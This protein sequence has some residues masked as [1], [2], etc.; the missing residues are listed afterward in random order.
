[1]IQMWPQRPKLLHLGLFFSA[2]LLGCGLAEL[3]GT[4]PGTK[5]TIWAPGGIF[6]ATLIASPRRTWP[7]WTLAGCLAE[8]LAQILWYH[9]PALAS[10]LIFLGNAVGAWVG[11]WLV[12]RVCAR[13]VRLDSL[14]EVL[15]FVTLGAGVAPLFSAT[16]GTGALAIFNVDSNSFGGTWPLFWIGDAS[17]VLIFGP[18]VLAILDRKYN[19]ARLSL[20]RWL[21]AIVLGLIFLA[22]GSFS[23]SG[24]LPFAFI[25][26][27]PLLWAAVRFEFKGAIVALALLALLTTAFTASGV[28]QFAGE[29]QRERQLMLQLFLA[30]CALSALIVAAISRQHQLA[31]ATLRESE[32]QLRELVDVVPVA[33]ARL[34][35]NGDPTFF[36]KRMIEFLGLDL[37]DLEGRDASPRAAAIAAALHPDDAAE[38]SEALTVSLANAVS[39]HRKYRLRSGTGE[40]RW[41][42]GR[43]EPLCNDDGSVAQWY[44][45]SVDIDDQVRLFREVAERESQIRCLVEADVI[46]IVI[47]DLDGTLIDANDAFLRMVGYDREDVRRGLGWLD[48]TPP[49]W[50]EVHAREEAEELA[51]TGM[52]QAREK[53]Y[54][55]K[56]GSRVPVLIGAACFEGN[57]SQ[58]V[59]YILDL[60][61]RKR[62]EAALLDRE[63]ELR[64]TQEQLAQASQ[65]AS[66]AELSASIAHEVNQPLA[67]IVANSHACERWLSAEPPNIARARI[68][69]ERIVR[70]A[71]SAADLVARVRSLFKPPAAVSASTTLESV[72]A[73]VQALL[74]EDITRRG[75][76]MRVDMETGLPPVAIDRVQLQ[77][78]LVNLIRNGMEAMEGVRDERVLGVRAHRMGDRVRGE[79]SDRGDG[80]EFPDRMFEPFFT[81]KPD[82]M[83]MG[84]AICR[85]IVERHGGRLW[86]ESNEPRGA[87]F[88]FELPT[89]TAVDR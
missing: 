53:E 14:R 64:R 4:V 68:T 3:L 24:H 81:T 80:L 16:L 25:I 18:L 62:A 31:V 5:V 74:T 60:S 26:M 44:G 88:V 21:E 6:M 79:I 1:M 8:M 42:E 27:P 56:D 37:T 48:I 76:R 54:F 59:A 13:R 71:N 36:N 7:S 69:A 49:E 29:T 63:E 40:Y 33:I 11:A 51:R 65:A 45:V 22:V 47:W 41:V 89:E 85:S 86:C 15:V 12:T 58:G 70:D 32:R 19:E 84:L 34:A 43:I 83:G 77:Q 82:G 9:S 35:P 2:Y 52:M 78:V 23:L 66:L 17:G 67:A 50:Q 73:S 46:G 20:A 28:G 57:S 30:I 87:R 61:E 39:F 10:L 55:R 72:V 75:V 38:F